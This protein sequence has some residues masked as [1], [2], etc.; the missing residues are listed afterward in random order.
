MLLTLFT[1]TPLNLRTVA[2]GITNCASTVLCISIVLAIVSLAI[3]VN[4][5]VVTNTHH[6]K[7]NIATIPIV[8]L[9]LMPYLGRHSNTRIHLTAGKSKCSDSPLKSLSSS[10]S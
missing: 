9:I 5:V 7:H 2:I 4:C 1:R 10:L 6:Q 8:R 3:Q